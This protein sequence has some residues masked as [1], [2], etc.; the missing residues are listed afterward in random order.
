MAELKEESIRDHDVNVELRIN[1]M[2]R[3]RNR[4]LD[5]V[6]PMLYKYIKIDMMGGDEEVLTREKIEI[7]T[8]KT[9]MDGERSSQR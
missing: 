1:E 4:E 9:Q 5:P 6:V 3:Q 8:S 2:K 7:N